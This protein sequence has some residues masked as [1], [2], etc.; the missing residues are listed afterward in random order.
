MT[1]LRGQAERAESEVVLM[2]N[3]APGT[4]LIE[5][6]SLVPAEDLGNDEF[7]Q[8]G[9]YL[10]TV[11]HPESK[12]TVYLECPPILAKEIAD[13]VAHNADL[14]GRWFHLADAEKVDGRWKVD[15]EVAPADAELGE[16]PWK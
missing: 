11:R 15:V 9:E 1:D 7:P 6:E 2:G 12:V 5:S 14:E 8:Y 13:Q 4:H 16:L 3:A 10:E